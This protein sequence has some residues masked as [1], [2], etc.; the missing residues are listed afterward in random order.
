MRNRAVLVAQ[1]E[2][3]ENL[4]TKTFWIG[5]LVVPVLIMLSAVV[6]IWLET[7]KAA[8][9]YAVI[10]RSGWLL[11]AIEQKAQE[12]D[13]ASTIELAIERQRLGG[14]AWETLPAPLKQAVGPLAS[15]LP[16]RPLSDLASGQA[17]ARQARQQQARLAGE[18]AA[19][20]L[21]DSAPASLAQ[22]GVEPG[23]LGR[24]WRELSP[25]ERGRQNPGLA[26][27]QFRRV[28]APAGD[29]AVGELNHRVD[30][31]ELF[32]YFVIGDDPMATSSPH[33]YVSRNLTD[34][35]LYEWFSGLAAEV[36]R[37]RRLAAQ[38]LDPG[39]ADWL[40][41]PIY[42]EPRKVGKG[43]AEE[44]VKAEDLLRQW[45]PMV[46]VYLLWISVFTT[47]NMLMMNTIEEKSN[48]IM[49]VLLSSVSP[50]ELLFGK[51]LGIAATG[52]T[53]IGTWVLFF[54]G[55]VE[56]V[57]I[58][59]GDKLPIDLGSVARD[60]RLLA[61][62]VVYFVLGY[63]LYASLLAGIGSVCNT[64]KE[65]QNLMTPVTLLLMVPFF[66]M[67]SVSRDPNGTLAKVLSFIPPFTPF[68]M[69]NRAAGPPS[70]SEYVLTTL[71]LV[72]SVALALWGA[73][74]IF[75]VGILMTGKPPRLGDLLRWLRAPV[76]QVAGAVAGGRGGKGEQ[77]PG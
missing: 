44:Q 51:I 26:S 30:A 70:L 74:K 27:A 71:L 1:R 37:D 6:P 9:T 31:G 55:A 8:R 45:A 52:L 24:W 68:V 59:V 22:L 2:Y 10:D 35:A 17:A 61:S 46:F 65:A 25:E 14:V 18:L 29:D 28:E 42:F 33:T 53:V 39:L 5:I 32:G 16:A 54:V 50:I 11:A 20:A 72:G 13:L 56:V 76:G 23:P 64:L 77:A 66:T 3:F 15:A 21:G 63:L 57:L 34:K 41:E 12:R 75:R 38:Q 19:A 60:P 36:V 48:R 58:F 62:F 49:E 40:K 73:A 69:M 67:M 43:G 4:R 7:I 47:A